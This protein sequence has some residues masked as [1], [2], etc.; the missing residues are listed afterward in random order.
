MDK[1]I[2]LSNNDLV[3][4]IISCLGEYSFMFCYTALHNPYIC[5]TLE[6]IGI[7]INNDVINNELYYFNCMKNVSQ[8]DCSSSL[9]TMRKL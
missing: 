2:Y 3:I 5:I 1:Q 8:D 7:Q 6:L 4:F 9:T